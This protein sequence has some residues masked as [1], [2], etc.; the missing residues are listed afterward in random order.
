MISLPE[1]GDRQDAFT[2]LAEISNFTWTLMDG[3]KGDTVVNKSLPMG[4]TYDSVGMNAVG[5][6]RA[7]MNTIRH[8]VRNKIQTALI[9]EDDADWDVTIRHQLKQYAHATRWLL[10]QEE[11]GVPFS[12]YG[13]GW[14]VLTIGHCDSEPWKNDMR[15]WVI[16]NDPTVILPHLRTGAWIPDMKPWEA[17]DSKHP[18]A[19]NH[20]RVCYTA[21]WVAC[22]TAYAL[23]L[24]GA[25]KL[26]YWM[27]MMPFSEKFDNG[28]GNVLRRRHDRSE[29]L[30]IGCFPTYIGISHG[31]GT[32]AKFSDIDISGG[33]HERAYSERL[34]FATRSNIDRI[35]RGDETFV[36]SY[37]VEEIEQA[38]DRSQRTPF[39]AK[40]EDLIG[41]KGRPEIVIKS[42]R[43]DGIESWESIPE[44]E[45][46]ER[47]GPTQET[48]L[49]RLE[50]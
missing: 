48:E 6:W 10:K 21:D 17:W 2:V 38:E 3:I 33:E 46:N 22:T 41:A 4:M 19:S 42:E 24:R 40:L 47:F 27:S 1:R 20:T 8:V 50:T 13:D 25:T 36:G 7:H 16:P 39:L 23:S 31:A 45:Y 43:D 5:S 29:I 35:L 44:A 11:K 49:S 14:D 37:T 28:L 12:P 9:F 34:Q 26:L 18:Q 15:R 32:G 30:G